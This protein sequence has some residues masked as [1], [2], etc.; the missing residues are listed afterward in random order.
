MVVGYFFCKT[1]THCFR[2]LVAL[3]EMEGRKEGRKDKETSEDSTLSLWK[4]TTKSWRGKT[5]LTN[6]MAAFQAE[7]W[8]LSLRISFLETRSNIFTK[9][10]QII[11]PVRVF[12]GDCN[13]FSIHFILRVYLDLILSYY[14]LFLLLFHPYRY[15][16][17]LRCMICS[18][19][20]ISWTNYRIQ[21][22][23]PWRDG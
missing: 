3:A 4:F 14:L 15:S 11:H 2:L 10:A 19:K 16:G 5:S 13:L 23:F 7:V 17:I 20:R 6:K 1:P 18:V 22:E 12:L 8:V 21:E 9:H